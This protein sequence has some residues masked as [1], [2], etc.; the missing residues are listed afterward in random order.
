MVRHPYLS[1]Q[2]ARERQGDW[3][4]KADQQRLTRELRDL[5]RAS[6]HAQHATRPTGRLLLRIR[7]A[8]PSA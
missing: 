6:Q 8:L 2:L 1:R 3:L 7:R 5:A 4:R